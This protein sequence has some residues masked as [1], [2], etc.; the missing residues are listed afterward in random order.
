MDQADAGALAPAVLRLTLLNGVEAHLADEVLPLGPP[1]RRAV[2][3]VLAF[4]RRQWV[5]ASS[6]LAA[7][8]DG[9]PP[10]SGVGVIQTYVSA[11]RRV[12]EPG[13]KPRTPPAVLLSGHGG[14]QLRIDDEQTDLGA[15][16][17]LVGEAGRAREA[18][19][20]ALAEAR[21][22]QALALYSGE[23]LA[24]LPGPFA[25]RQRMALA[26]RRL[27]VV[28]D[29]LEVAVA[30]GRSDEVIDRLRVLTAEHPLRERP[31]AVLMRALYSRGRQSEALDVYRETRNR[32]VDQLGVEP[33]EELRSL[34]RQI[35][36]GL[37]QPAPSRSGSEG[38]QSISGIRSQL[39]PASLTLPAVASVLP[40]DAVGQEGRAVATEV[41]GSTE[42]AAGGGIASG[43]VDEVTRVPSAESPS[44]SLTS[45]DVAVHGRSTS[46]AE[47]SVAV[48]LGMVAALWP[49]PDSTAPL[50]FERDHDLSRIAG[51]TASAAKGNGGLVVISGRPGYGKSQLLDEVARRVPGARRID[52]LPACD[53]A[54]QIGLIGELM[55]SA[56]AAHDTDAQVAEAV[57]AKLIEDSATGPL[58]V[59]VD[60]AEQLDERSVRV[61][62]AVAPRLRRM[63]VLFVLALDESSWEP[64]ILDL[65]ARIEPLAVAILRPGGLGIAAIEALYERRTGTVCPPGLAADIQQAT[66]DIPLLAGA[67]ITDLAALR[68]HG[69]IPE[70][71]PDGCYS[72]SVSRLLG[73][74]S[75]SGAAML[76]ALAVLHDLAPTIEVLA[77]ACA[78]PVGV[79]RDRCELLAASG[80]LASATPPVLRHRLIGNT[81]RRLS[82]RAGTDRFR[83]AAAEQARSAGYSA[84][85]VAAYLGDLAGVQ[86]SRWTVVLADAAEECLRHGL[87]AEA[88][89]QLAAA[90]RI[91]APQ[92]R[93]DILVR[94]GQL[95][96]W[97]NPA[98][99]RAHL[100]EAL[101]SQRDRRVAPTA[102]IPLAWTMSTRWQAGAAMALLGEVLAE[103][104]ARDPVAA[105]NI[106]S[107][108]W[109][110]AGLTSATWRDFVAG[111]RATGSTDQITTAVLTWDDA[112]GV[113][114]TARATIA[115]FPAGPDPARGWDV[116][117]QQLIGLLAHLSMW[118]G[119]LAL[120]RQ[121]SEQRNDHHF[122]TI[123]V[124][125][126]IL[127]S[128]VLLRCG[129]YR[130]ALREVAPMVGT[131]GEES[132]RP[133]L[134]LVAQ[135]AHALLGLGR[136]T[137]AERWLDSVTD[138]ANPETWEWTVVIHVKG[139]VCAARGESRQAIA[140]FMDCG[141]RVAAVG[142]RNPAHIPW[143]SSA[144]VE[145]VRLGER[146][147][148]HELAT[149]ELEIAR[150][151]ETPGT[152]GRALRATALAAPGGIDADLLDQA[153]GLLRGYDSPVELIPALLELA[154]VCQ[155]SGE[156]ERAGEL[157]RE[158][159]S[160]AETIGA[161]RYLEL[162][163]DLLEAPAEG[164]TSG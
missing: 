122:G 88:V 147:R 55:G 110:V 136:L 57:C 67:L 81:I 61:L 134:A 66:A 148:A 105:R 95:E 40:D 127:R 89:R 135:Y 138:H 29:S 71:L 45:E 16:D 154:A 52:L 51:W 119:D 155:D 68:D 36:E 159:R 18:G 39:A 76:R 62:T 133:P 120:A 142:I 21:Y 140:H 82:G 5:S 139:L 149:A 130:R 53:G 141:R 117:P 116:L 23:P 91:T 14:Y 1:Q 48:R 158:A 143:R 161:T 65:H 87:I 99:A 104:E 6:L 103:T 84:R 60:D 108:S 125:R 113:H 3:C 137:E 2:L 44:T 97:T 131:L 163:G 102:L 17:R 9:V 114:R 58:V 28:E 85:Q 64:A 32:L 10:A 35:L 124:Y 128:E 107:A 100:E 109:A 115:R 74:Y 157:R 50:V 73:R 101:Q 41:P 24:G 112:F 156:L 15:F 126:L 90:L 59:L 20:W 121:L 83:I 42:E 80:I 4:R 164:V 92:G 37:V 153:V 8:Y 106:R 27:A 96:L 78:E 31:R 111:L 54:P 160:H 150:Q 63:P 22:A 30:L 69:R 25:Q 47:E 118:A 70:Y 86:Y 145:L 152:I 19:D 12:L 43:S 13:R 132:I 72:R 7:L 144:A 11:L 93:D 49:E 98:A 34:H 46:A 151:W 77:A 146:A 33:G 129:D 75:P 94:L 79:V 123:D 56:T 38:H 26:E 162:I